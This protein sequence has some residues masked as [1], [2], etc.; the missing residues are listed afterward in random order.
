MPHRRPAG[1][2]AIAGALLLAGCAG[3]PKG[4]GRPP[5]APPPAA[6]PNIVLV[7]TD[8]L[9]WN[10]VEH[11]PRVQQM[12]QQ[13]LTFSR[14]FVSNSLCCPS[15]A[16]ILSG[17]Y[18]HNTRVLTNEA[19][20]GGFQAFLRDGAERETFATALQ[21]AG[22]R[23]ALMGKYLNDYDPA[24]VQGGSR[25]YI[26][27]G[28]SDWRA[29][30]LAYREYGYT[31]NENGTL[32]RYGNRPR[33]YLTDVL[34]AKG[35][36]FLTGAPAGRPFLLKIST[37]APHSPYVPAPRHAR[38]FPGLRAPRPPSFNEADLSD[39]PGWLRGYP[40]LNPAQIADIDRR[41]RDRVR[42]V[43]SIDELVGRLLAT[44]QARGL[45]RDTYVVFTSD[46]GLHL[47]EHRMPE[48]KATAFDTDTHVPLIVRGPGVPRG[49][50]VSALT[51]NTDLAPTFQELAGTPVGPRVD[52]RSL[53]PF[54][55]GRP[56]TGWRQ[57]ALIEH[58]DPVISPTDPDRHRR[59]AG[60]PT[61]HRALRTENELYVEY[62]GG[63]R[64]YY[65]LVRDPHQL[66][67][68]IGRLPP[69]RQLALSQMMYALY[70]CSGAGCRKADHR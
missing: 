40:R 64:E 65:D 42:M 29:T 5:P 11:M 38:S 66:D 9:S 31:L 33:D 8:D 13:G 7:L 32:V 62:D 16:S 10:L 47:G 50:T 22:Y 49:R 23:T 15:R 51:Q 63:E 70:K 14:Y 36:E 60:Y 67:N 39:K 2:L 41:Y 68:A 3:A 18:P 37:F 30:S 53:V 57:G 26:P 12:R 27:P 48:G 19:P 55:R 1:A 28:W 21:S 45:D 44:L 24:K 54:L 34:A 52:G 56:V 17:R 6:R 46:N 69:E 20:T 59:L 25:A 4:P 58:F 61:P 35:T 43:Q